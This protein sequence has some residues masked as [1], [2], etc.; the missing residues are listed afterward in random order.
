MGAFITSYDLTQTPPLRM[1]SFALSTEIPFALT[2]AG[3]YLFVGTSTE[4]LVLDATSPASPAK[5]G[6]LAH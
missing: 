3:H 2:A 4:L 6:S 1:G 5:V